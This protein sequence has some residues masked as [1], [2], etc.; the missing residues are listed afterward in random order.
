[1][2][3]AKTIERVDAARGA[4]RSSR[5]GPVSVLGGGRTARQRVDQ[6]WTN[7]PAA[8]ESRRRKILFFFLNAPSTMTWMNGGVRRFQSQKSL[9]GN[10]QGKEE[11]GRQR[12]NWAPEFAA[13]GPAF[14]SR[15]GRRARTEW[16]RRRLMALR[17]VAEEK[18]QCSRKIQARCRTHVCAIG[19]H[20]HG[21][22]GDVDRSLRS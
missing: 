22:G 3:A 20:K 14:R 4:G 8:T 17:Q 5:A 15:R 11:E 16:S 7:E 12:K 6:V 1:M 19:T 13:D 10:R 9:R 2:A 21:A 18:I